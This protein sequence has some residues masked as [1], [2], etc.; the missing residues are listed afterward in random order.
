MILDNAITIIPPDGVDVNIISARISDL[1]DE[2][3]SSNVHK[4]NEEYTISISVPNRVNKNHI[5]EEIKELCSKLN[6]EYIDK[7]Y[8][9]KLKHMTIESVLKEIKLG[10]RGHII[11]IIHYCPLYKT[12]IMLNLIT[13]Y[14]T[15][16]HGIAF[17]ME[18][19][20]RICEDI[21]NFETSPLILGLLLNIPASIL[22]KIQKERFSR[23]DEWIIEELKYY[24]KNGNYRIESLID[25]Y[26]QNYH[27]IIS[28]YLFEYYHDD[29]AKKHPDILNKYIISDIKEFGSLFKSF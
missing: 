15:L 10:D 25:H 11:S 23:A 5:T 29:L 2:L 26:S 12:N 8:K 7:E 14:Y 22:C 19:I 17:Q 16:F 18:N 28:K 1:M 3:K 24:E 27:A 20:A 4:K 9:D 6:K 13:K 21:F